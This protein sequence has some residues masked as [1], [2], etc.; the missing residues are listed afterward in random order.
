[1]AKTSLTFRAPP[2]IVE[3]MDTMAA[4]L[5]TTRSEI[6]NRSL[7]EFPTIVERQ[8]L[9]KQYRHIEK[10]MRL[11]Q[12]RM[13]DTAHWA[14]SAVHIIGELA[15]GG[16]LGTEAFNSLQAVFSSIPLAGA[17]DEAGNAAQQALK[18]K[19]SDRALE[20]WE[21]LEAGEGG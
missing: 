6:I 5:N 9:K 16:K 18:L 20:R 11:L 21:A 13:R 10:V 4:K 1:M 3:K 8:N 12:K 15:Q 14:V 19:L 2:E 7:F 17:P